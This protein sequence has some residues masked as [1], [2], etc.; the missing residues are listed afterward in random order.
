MTI[1]FSIL[2]WLYHTNRWILYEIQE[3]T[4]SGSQPKTELF[5]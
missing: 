1:R 5:R 3:T 4:I 2:Y